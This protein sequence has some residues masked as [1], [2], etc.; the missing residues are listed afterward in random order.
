MSLQVNYDDDFFY[1]STL[2]K[3]VNWALS[4]EL[5]PEFF[6]AKVHGDII[7]LDKT[8]SKLDMSLGDHGMVHGK[9]T[10]LRALLRTERLFVDCLSGLTQ[11]EN[12][13]STALLTHQSAYL[14]LLTTHRYRLTAIQDS[15]DDMREEQ[16]EEESISEAEYRVLLEPKIEEIE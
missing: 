3:A 16:P 10:Y 2:I 4:L 15:I 8:L 6:A 1:L 11:S 9:L 5:D 13:L 12:A 14:D 7:F